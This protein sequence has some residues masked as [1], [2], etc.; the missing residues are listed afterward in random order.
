MQAKSSGEKKGIAP[1]HTQTI[2]FVK[3]NITHS[4]RE[5]S[6]LQH[7]NNDNC[8]DDNNNNNNNVALMR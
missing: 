1:D 7:D 6:R 8:N 4:L 5:K 3:K 2:L